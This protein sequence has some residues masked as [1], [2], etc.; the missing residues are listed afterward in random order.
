[1][2]TRHGRNTDLV[3]STPLADRAPPKSTLRHP[4]N[5]TQNL[6]DD[7]MIRTLLFPPL[8]RD[9]PVKQLVAPDRQFS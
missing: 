1:M 9:I 6:F 8:P 3:T 5:S 2:Q 4:L 7:N